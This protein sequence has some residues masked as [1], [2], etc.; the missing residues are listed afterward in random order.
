MHFLQAL[1]LSFPSVAFFYSTHHALRGARDCFSLR[2]MQIYVFAPHCESPP[3]P[4]PSAVRNVMCAS[5]K[6][7][8]QL[9]PHTHAARASERLHRQPYYKAEADATL[10]VGGWASER[11]RERVYYASLTDSFIT[12]RFPRR[13]KAHCERRHTH[14]TRRSFASQRRCVSSGI[15]TLSLPR[16]QRHLAVLTRENATCSDMRCEFLDEIPLRL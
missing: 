1:S 8:L 5:F 10:R 3:R 16:T 11:E 7:K 13:N 14:N 9:H 2:G 6:L 12:G 15:F 4:A